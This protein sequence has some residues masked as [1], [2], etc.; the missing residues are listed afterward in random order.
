MVQWL[1]SLTMGFITGMT[2]TPYP[3]FLGPASQ[4]L[5]QTPSKVLE[6]RI[7]CSCFSPPPNTH[8]LYFLDVA[9][10]IFKVDLRS[11]RV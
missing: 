6:Y 3:L 10:K 1:P 5:P 2:S 11:R 8:I 9:N 4:P 7:R